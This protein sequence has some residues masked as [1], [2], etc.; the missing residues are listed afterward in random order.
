MNEWGDADAAIEQY[1]KA[2][3]LDP[4]NLW[5]TMRVADILI[6]KGKLD[7]AK[8]ELNGILKKASDDW[9]K[10]EAKRKISDIDGRPKE[11]DMVTKEAAL[12]PAIVEVVK[13][14][15]KT[16]EVKAEAKPKEKKKKG[17]FFGR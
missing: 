6:A 12:P 4:S 2:Q 9:M 7:E 3:S 8:K 13:E 1:R 17:W 14:D 10:E 16:E 15:I 5:Y 11:A